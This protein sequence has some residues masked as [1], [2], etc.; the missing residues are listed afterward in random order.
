MEQELKLLKGKYDEL[1]KKHN[2]LRYKYEQAVSELIALQEFISSGNDFHI[3]HF[4]DES[5]NVSP[6]KLE[7][8]DLLEH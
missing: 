7:P 8:V 3:Q 6:V 4:P 5:S 1:E 2:F